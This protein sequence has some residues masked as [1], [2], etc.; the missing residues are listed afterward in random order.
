MQP[1]PNR[2]R[3]RRSYGDVTAS[4]SQHARISSA[5]TPRATACDPERGAFKPP[6][7]ADLSG[8]AQR[9]RRN[10]GSMS[11][12]ASNCAAT[13]R[14]FFVVGVECA[15]SD[16]PEGVF[17]AAD[18]EHAGRPGHGLDVGEQIAREHGRSL[19]AGHCTLP[20]RRLSRR[21]RHAA[22]VAPGCDSYR[23]ADRARAGRADGLRGLTTERRFPSRIESR[24]AS[25]CAGSAGRRPSSGLPGLLGW[26]AYPGRGWGW[27]SCPRGR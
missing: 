1:K 13:A 22:S 19:P 4:R 16:R 14:V 26:R 18:P 7:T 6:R 21:H 27:R 10:F 24:R 5:D 12:S 3:A 15:L 17:G 2:A 11:S 8:P 23:S 25:F 9:T 20:G